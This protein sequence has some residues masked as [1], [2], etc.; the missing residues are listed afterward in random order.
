MI[1]LVRSEL[2]RMA[3]IRSSWVSIVLFG[4][5]AASFGVL[6]AYWWALFVGVGA[7]G[8]SVFTV[9]QHYRH[10]T[11]ALLYLAR[12][13]RIQVLIAQVVT[14]VAVAWGFAALT[15]ITVLPRAKTSRTGARSSSS[16][17]WLCSAPGWR[18]SCAGPHGF[19]TAS[20]SGSSWSRA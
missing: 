4:A 2:Y 12:P 16:R 7:F 15:G 20:R 1:A 3:T 13:R 14:T 8:I 10:R 19:C 9:A 11:A 17:S 6:N 18:P 5:V